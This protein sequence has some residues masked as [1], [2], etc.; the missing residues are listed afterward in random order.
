MLHMEVLMKLSSFAA[1]SLLSLA[2]IGAFPTVGLRAQDAAAPVAATA[3][4]EL[5]KYQYTGVLNA[6]NVYIRSGPGENDYPVTKLSKGD[7][8]TV[9]GVKVDWLK[10]LPPDG[11]YCLVS[12]ALVDRR[13]DGS[14]GRVHADAVN[15]NVRIGSN[16][17][18]MI[19]KIVTQLQGNV[20]VKIVGEQDDYYR[21]APPPGVY[22]YI[23]KKFVNVVKQVEVVSN[24]GN[25]EVKAPST[26]PPA[27]INV[28]NTPA[29]TDPAAPNTGV[30]ATGVTGSGVTGTGVTGNPAVAPVGSDPILAANPPTTR[31]SDP[32]V[33][34]SEQD[35]DKL[36]AM[37]NQTANQSLDQQPLD[38]MITGYQ[39]VAADKKAPESM[40]R[41]ADFRLAGLKIRK[42][43]MVDYKSKLEADKVA[44]TRIQPLNIEHEELQQRYAQNDIKRYTAVGTLRVSALPYG[45]KAMYRLTDPTTSRTIIYIVSDDP[46]IAKSEGMFVAI[47]GSVT[48]DTRRQIKFIT[49]TA[50]NTISPEQ[51]TKGTIGATFVPPSLTPSA[52][53]TT[54]GTAN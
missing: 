9:V 7:P 29:G 24:N 17:N 50:I 49:P 12:K 11:T 52:S 54:P 48:D 5:T 8:V 3:D 25:V 46:M 1:A 36:E 39:K 19:A 16:I 42:Q 30:A 21:I 34:A 20:D 22:A 13:G 32:A 33:A 40:L 43:A 26:T 28:P 10:I 4:T 51:I 31:P 6:D 35:F 44:A 45:D 41:M 38:E 15:V 37:F 18:S 14:I 47:D 53:T 2:I 23:H 27:P